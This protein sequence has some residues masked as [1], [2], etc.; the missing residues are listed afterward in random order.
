MDVVCALAGQIDDV[1]RKIEKRVGLDDVNHAPFTLE[2]IVVVTRAPLENVVVS[3]FAPLDYRQRVDSFSAN[4]DVAAGPAHQSVVALASRKVIVPGQSEDFVVA[5]ATEEGVD[6]VARRRRR[7][8]AAVAEERVVADSTAEIIASSP[9]DERVVTDTAEERVA[10]VRGHCPGCNNRI[11][12]DPVVAFATVDHRHREKMV[13]RRVVRVRLRQ[14]ER[15]GRAIYNAGFQRLFPRGV[16]VDLRFFACGRI[17]DLLD[18]DKIDSVVDQPVDRGL[19]WL[20]LL[21]DHGLASNEIDVARDHERLI[22]GKNV[23]IGVLDRDEF[24]RRLLDAVDPIVRFAA[25]D[26][27]DWLDIATVIGG[28]SSR[29]D[30]AAE[31]AGHRVRGDLFSGA[32]G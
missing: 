1:F 6:S 10:A 23:D 28:L 19:A 15:T 18:P 12:D 2:K 25:D 31:D 26:F 4:D 8:V 16:E 14:L 21:V 29:I 20:A 22:V 24:H 27:G 30:Q 3:R 7:S 5:D 13:N 11:A 32:W 9:T 17:G